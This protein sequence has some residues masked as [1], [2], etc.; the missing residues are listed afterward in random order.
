MLC[1]IQQVSRQASADRACKAGCLLFFSEEHTFGEAH[2]STR[3]QREMSVFVYSGAAH[4][5]QL[6][7]RFARP[8]SLPPLGSAPPV[9]L[10]AMPPSSPTFI[11]VPISPRSKRTSSTARGT[12]ARVCTFTESFF[13]HTIPTTELIARFSDLGLSKQAKLEQFEAIR[14]HRKSFCKQQRD[15]F[16]QRRDEQAQIMRRRRAER[17][18]E[19]ARQEKLRLENRAAITIQRYAR[20]KFCHL[21][22]AREAERV[23]AALALQAVTRG[24]FTRKHDPKLRRHRAAQRM[25]KITRNTLEARGFYFIR[26]GRRKVDRMLA[27]LMR[28]RADLREHA[29]RVLQARGR[30]F[31]MRL[32]AKRKR[33][34][35]L[36]ADVRIIQLALRLQARVRGRKARARAKK[37]RDR[38]GTRSHHFGGYRHSNYNVSSSQVNS[39]H[40]S[41]AMSRA[42]HGASTRTL[43][44]KVSPSSGGDSPDAKSSKRLSGAVKKRTSK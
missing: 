10:L 20:G 33:L 36:S 43:S 27:P 30:R 19:R 17:E 34:A 16:T 13:D 40:A 32:R 12:A 2:T 35:E 22:I 24:A 8:V 11:P 21:A 26:E 1:M 3:A 44:G 18:L 23:R 37:K 4:G 42:T 15:E 41:P 38:R 25:Q 14:E 6:S 39:Q 31:L 7:P 5:L 29:A 9:P 28:M